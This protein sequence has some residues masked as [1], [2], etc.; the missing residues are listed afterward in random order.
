MAFR[1]QQGSV[2]LLVSFPHSSTFIP[3]EIAERMT[4]VG[5]TV[6]DTDWFLP[7]LYQFLESTGASTIEAGFSRYVIDANRS[8]DGENLYPGQPTPELVP[9]QTFAGKP[10]WM[11]G[12]EPD[13]FEIGQR[14]R[15]YWQPYHDKIGEE[16]TRIK[17][18]HGIAV[19]FDAHSILSRV[20][21]LFDGQLPD[22]NIGTA[23]GQSC[24]ASLESAIGNF[25]KQQTVCSHII[26]GR[27][28]G[29]YITR[30]F[31][32]PDRNIHAV[33][34]ELSQLRYMNETTGE[35]AE[36]LAIE[37]RS[38]LRRIIETIIEWTGT[39]A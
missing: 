16:L 38:V 35:W 23:R 28:V 12:Q 31:G 18:R 37:T 11:P 1:F 13:P 27:F 4:N 3:A 6:P 39:Q 5:Q 34:L 24:A 30:H 25:L 32:Q 8:P 19:L 20:P 9:L 10:I 29:G 7:R 21:R 2:P 17:H 15:N 33:Q 36:D 22:I 14:T 26:N